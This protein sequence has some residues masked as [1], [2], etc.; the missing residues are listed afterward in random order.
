MSLFWKK[1]FIKCSRGHLLVF[2]QTWKK[3]SA[4]V[5]KTSKII[6]KCSNFQDFLS[7]MLLCKCSSAHVES[8]SGNPAK[9]FPVKIQLFLVE[10]QKRRKFI[11][12]REF[13]WRFSLCTLD[14]CFDTPDN[15]FFVKIRKNSIKVP[16]EM[17]IVLFTFITFSQSFAEDT[18]KALLATLPNVNFFWQMTV[19]FAQRPKTI[20]QE[21]FSPKETSKRSAA[22]VG[23]TFKKFWQKIHTKSPIFSLNDQ[24]TWAKFLHSKET[25]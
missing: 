15:C 3:I 14:Y 17:M 25:S 8:S 23:C 7:E 24:K 13:F 9:I 12:S 22:T 11:F 5:P 19:I 2:C 21:L 20:K 6:R 4:T 10:V 18:W 1:V 16:K